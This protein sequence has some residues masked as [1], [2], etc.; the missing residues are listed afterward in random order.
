MNTDSKIH[1]L[2][3]KFYPSGFT[4]VELLV[5][6]FIAVAFLTSGYQLYSVVIKDGGETR[7]RSIAGYTTHDYL[8]R[9][10][11]DATNPCTVQNPLNNS[12]ITVTGLSSVTVTVAISCPFSSTTSISKVLVT[13]KYNTPQQ[14]VSD[15]TYVK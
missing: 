13:L 14:T 2:N 10:K 7:A 8:Q 6:L 1:N 15:A 4:A 5:T 12:V 3:S 11:P 9:Y